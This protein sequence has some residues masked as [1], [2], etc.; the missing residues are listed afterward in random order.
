[1]SPSEVVIDYH[2]ANLKIFE[3]IHKSIL[4][5]NYLAFFCCIPQKT[6]K[7]ETMKNCANEIGESFSSLHCYLTCPDRFSSLF[8]TSQVQFFPKQLH[9]LMVS[10]NKTLS[11]FK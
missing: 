7:M 9:L 5:A 8:L 1:M 10:M 4:N 6:M 3:S 11:E 2:L